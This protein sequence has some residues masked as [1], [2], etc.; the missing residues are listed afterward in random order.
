MGRDPEAGS[1]FQ[2]VQHRAAFSKQA[3]S[4]GFDHDAQQADNSKAQGRRGKAPFAFVHE[5]QIRPRVNR[6]RNRRGFAGVQR[7]QKA[8]CQGAVLRFLNGQAVDMVRIGAIP[9]QFFG[10][11]ARNPDL[12]VEL[13]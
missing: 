11:R 3:L 12:F 7:V 5:E 10:H 6:E 13:A 8:I 2:F 9:S 4:F 1:L